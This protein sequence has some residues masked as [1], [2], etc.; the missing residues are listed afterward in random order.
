MI[1]LLAALL[2]AAAP[3]LEPDAIVAAAP[4]AAWR[5]I[6]PDNLMIIET[7]AGT[8]AMELAPD[9]APAHVAAVRALVAAGRF[10]GG[11]ITR[12][13]DN[14]VVQWAAKPAPGASAVGQ[15]P[16]DRPKRTR[17]QPLPAE[18]E[19]PAKGLAITPLGFPDAYAEAGFADG[20]PVA[21][22]RKAGT[23]WLAHCYGTVGAGHDMPPDSGD[24]S[25]LYAVIGHAPRHLDRNIALV[26]RV[27]SGLEPHAALKRGTEALGFYATPAEQTPVIRARLASAMPDAPRFE[28]M[29]TSSDSFAAYK[30]ARANRSGFFVRPAGAVDLCNVR[31]PVR[32]AK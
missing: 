21:Q 15:P 17:P 9:F 3:P 32:V 31:V 18:F 14:Y 23:A 12:V 10:D 25:E 22:D 6:A 5:P 16:A 20:W 28:V 7:A 30:T 4:P 27:V 11:S 2:A 13:Q 24:G 19:R 8:M 26:G 1:L 29:Q